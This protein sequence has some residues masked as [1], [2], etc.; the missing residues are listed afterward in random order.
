MILLGSFLHHEELAAIVGRAIEDRLRPDDAPRLKVILN[1]N[2]YVVRIYSNWFAER[3][4]RNVLGEGVQSRPARTKGELKDLIVANPPYASGRVRELIARYRRYPEDYYRETPYEG[5][6]FT[7]GEPPRYAGSR[8]IKR[9]R[10]TSEPIGW[11]SRAT[12]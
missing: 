4:F 11:G 12:S 6:V 5:R 3:L 2:A 10:P 9:V 8:R 1:L 7:T